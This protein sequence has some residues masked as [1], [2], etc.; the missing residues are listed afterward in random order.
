MRPVLK[1]AV[2]LMTS[3]LQPGRLYESCQRD[4]DCQGKYYCIDGFCTLHCEVAGTTT[5]GTVT[6][7]DPVGTCE[8]T[9][10]CVETGLPTAEKVGCCQIL[11][12]SVMGSMAAGN[13]VPRL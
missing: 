12:P 10:A 7:V 4:G 13:C 1:L 3:C 8:P 6:V 11:K 2:L 5:V 9:P